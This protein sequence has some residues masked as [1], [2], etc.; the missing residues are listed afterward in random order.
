MKL[1]ASILSIAS[2]VLLSACAGLPRGMTVAEYCL[3]PEKA[4]EGVCQL[5]M[6]ID[7]NTTALANTDLSLREARAMADRAMSAANNAQSS[8]NAAQ[9]SADRANSLAAQA[10][11]RARASSDNLT[12]KT[13]TVQK[14]NVGSCEPGYTLTSC[15][16]SRFTHRAGGL[17]ILREIDDKQ[18]RFHDRVLEMKVRCC[19]TSAS[20]SPGTAPAAL[21]RY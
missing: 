7:G 6:E 13:L 2:A 18:C 1:K 21:R 17:S 10:M 8:A 15:T 12:C 5:K 19:K 20:Y 16:Q 14:T 9:A 3:N 4:Q 11:D